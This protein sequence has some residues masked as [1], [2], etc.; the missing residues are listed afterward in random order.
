MEKHA[1]KGQSGQGNT[2]FHELNII[3][4]VT[5]TFQMKKKITHLHMVT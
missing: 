2:E 4:A 3:V 5:V 1:Q